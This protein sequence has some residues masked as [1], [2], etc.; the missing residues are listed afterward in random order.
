MSKWGEH[1]LRRIAGLEQ[2]LPG[3]SD[4]QIKALVNQT[5]DQGRKFAAG[6]EVLIHGEMPPPST[7][8][9]LDLRKHFHMWEEQADDLILAA[10][11]G[12]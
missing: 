1:T 7:A 11:K 4:P 9:S 3:V 5:I 6:W 12:V 2:A 10:R 8:D